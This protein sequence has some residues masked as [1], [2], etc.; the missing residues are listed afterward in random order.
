[1]AAGANEVTQ[2]I[3]NIATVSQENGAAAEEVSASVE[4]VSAQVEEVTASAQSLAAMAQELQALVAQF[5]LP[6]D[7]AHTT[8]PQAGRV[9]ATIPVPVTLDDDNGQQLEELQWIE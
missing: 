4:E 6:G 9:M 8:T 3:E 2:A 5:K 7:T 1:M